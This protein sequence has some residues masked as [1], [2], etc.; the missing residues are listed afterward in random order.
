MDKYYQQKIQSKV[1]LTLKEIG[2]YGNIII[3]RPHIY[4]IKC[5]IIHCFLT[6]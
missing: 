3:L 5:Y 4:Q 6:K 2:L 1:L